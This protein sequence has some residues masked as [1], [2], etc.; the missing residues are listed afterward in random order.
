MSMFS[1]TGNRPTYSPFTNKLYIL[2]GLSVKET[3]TYIGSVEV[4]V[5][6]PTHTLSLFFSHCPQRVDSRSRHPI[7][8]YSISTLTEGRDQPLPTFRGSGTPI[9][10]G[11][12]DF[13]GIIFIPYQFL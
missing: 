9:K 6:P 11:V 2:P 10:K 13:P 4:E 8:K 5:P 1:P 12:D 7:L 3:V